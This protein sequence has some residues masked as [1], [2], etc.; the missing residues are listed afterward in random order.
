MENAVKFTD[1]GRVEVKEEHHGDCVVI[2][3]RDTGPGVP[4]ED[5]RSIFEPFQRGHSKKLGTG[6]GLAIARRAIEIQG[7]TLQVESKAESVLTFGSLWGC[8]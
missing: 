8:Q 6:M 5:L 2:H 7:G 1:S 4:E 3:V